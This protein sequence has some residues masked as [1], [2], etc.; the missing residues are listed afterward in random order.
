MLRHTA[1]MFIRVAEASVNEQG[2]SI[3]RPCL[4]LCRALIHTISYYYKVG[5]M[6]D[7]HDITDIINA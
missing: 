3:L 2:R 4:S 1:R 6:R 5:T 7:H